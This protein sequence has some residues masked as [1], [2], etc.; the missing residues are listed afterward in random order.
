MTCGCTRS[1]AHVPED[2]RT[3]LDGPLP[4]R[5]GEGW[6]DNHVY[7]QS[8][9]M[10][11]AYA[12]AVMLVAALAALAALADRRC[13]PGVAPAGVDVT[14][15]RASARAARPRFV[16]ESCRH[17]GRQVTNRLPGAGR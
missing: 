8:N 11:P 3:A 9:P 12:T 4:G 6:A 5:V 16:S 14:L 7:I 2:F 13:P 10:E 17:D 1:A 15:A